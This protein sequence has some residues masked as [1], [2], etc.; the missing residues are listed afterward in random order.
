MA[1]GTQTG[2]V[3]TPLLKHDEERQFTQASATRTMRGSALRAIFIISLSTRVHACCL[4]L[5]SYVHMYI[6]WKHLI[7]TSFNTSTYIQTLLWLATWLCIFWHILSLRISLLFAAAFDLFAQNIY[8]HS[9]PS[10]L[11]SAI[12]QIGVTILSTTQKLY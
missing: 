5:D 3:Q 2:K 8:T 6:K 12:F 4:K 11:H 7:K 10:K 1:L 9:H